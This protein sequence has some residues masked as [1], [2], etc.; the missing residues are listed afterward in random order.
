MA[1]VG[2]SP[3][4]DGQHDLAVFPEGLKGRR[5]LL[6]TESF[7]P[8]NGVSRTTLMLVNHL[9]ANGCHVAVVA[10]H[11][12]TKLNTFV[13]T[14]APAVRSSSTASTGSITTTTTTK[15]NIE[16]RLH[17][18]PVPFNPE[19]SIV[20]LVRLSALYSRTFGGPPDLIYLASP[21]SLGFQVMFQLRQRPEREQIPVLCNF[22]T[23]LAGYC[24]TLFPFPLGGIAD[25]AFASV[26]S[27]LFRH[28]SVKTIFYPSTYVRRYLERHHVPGDKME[29]LTRGVDTELFKPD[30]RNQSLRDHIAPDGEII[31]ICVARLAAEKSFDFLAMV[32]K[33]LNLRGLK[34]KLYIVGGNR[35]AEVETEIKGLFA[36]LE[37]QGKVIFA[38]FRVGEELAEAYASADLFLHCSISETFGLVVLESFAS[39]VPV[40]A[41][42]MGGPSNTVQDGYSGFLTPPDDLSAF[43]DRVI[44]LANDENMR[45]RF[46]RDAL[47]QAREA[48]WDKI[49]NK[50]AW[51]MLDEIEQREAVLAE[52]QL[53]GDTKEP[54]GGISAVPVFGWLMLS[55]A[56]RETLVNSRLV[57]ALGVILG[58]WGVVGVYLG[59]TK[60]NR[61]VRG[62][63]SRSSA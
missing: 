53:Q 21:A 20:Y 38:G 62:M 17:G 8:V 1:A 3:P 50:V 40:V 30:R 39:G 44:L 59:F 15:K 31:L 9:R 56:F 60:A 33:E 42:D 13:P 48:T 23:D 16:V 24:K 63:F 14:L 10:P 49:N 52:M 41:R 18:Y 45:A 11:N 32:A 12:P 43:V 29:I 35:Q 46:G 36:D 54:H 5:V 22:Q 61:W 47:R 28:E 51:K 58:F 34:F 19:L 6:C 55:G 26:Q 4:A 2:S 7:G 25:Y 37:G 27:F 57:G